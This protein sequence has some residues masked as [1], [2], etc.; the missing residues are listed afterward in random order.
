MKTVLLVDD[1]HSIALLAAIVLEDEGYRVVTA[2]NGKLALEMLDEVRPDLI[3]SD[4][5]MPLMDG[6]EFGC[7]VRANPA[8]SATPIVMTSGL[9]EEALKERFQQ[10]NA[11]LRKPF[12]DTLLLQVVGEV[13]RKAEISLS[14]SPAGRA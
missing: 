13:M 7:T 5:M 6:A 10:Y 4:F 14:S 8:Y 1:E 9:P 2:A 11:F 12:F 3:I